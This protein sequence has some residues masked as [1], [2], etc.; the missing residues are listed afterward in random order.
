M[1]R[2]TDQGTV[3]AETAV[4]LPSL[5]LL[6][7]VA[8]AAIQA[9]TTQLACVDAARVGARALARGEQHEAVR[10]LVLQVAP[11]GARSQISSDAAFARVELRAPVR[12]VP[13]LTAPF[14]VRAQAATPREERP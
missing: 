12:L 2:R 3:T 10:R 13:G 11:P 1:A 14:E 8:L 4:A 9:A 5:M 7:G 6:L